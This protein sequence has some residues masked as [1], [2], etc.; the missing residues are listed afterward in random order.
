MVLY[1]IENIML[2]EKHMKNRILLLALVCLLISSLLIACNSKEAYRII[3]VNSF[4]G[5]TSMNRGE[6]AV[7]L[8]EGIQLV[9]NDKVTT[10]NDGLIEL[11][12][13]SDKSLVASENT[14]F[15]IEALGNE[16]Q[17][18][19]TIN[20]EYGTALIDIQNQ[21]TEGSE[22][23]VVTPNATLSVRG[24]TF[25]V[26][27][28]VTTNETI[29]SVTDG[30]V[31]ATTN[32]QSREVN[33]GETVVIRDVN[34]EAGGDMGSGED[35]DNEDDENI[36]HDPSADDFA[37]SE[38]ISFYATDLETEE[39]TSIGV[40]AIEGFTAS[41]DAFGVTQYS[42]NDIVIKIFCLDNDF[43]VSEMEG[44]REPLA[45][46][47]YETNST[48]NEVLADEVLVNDDGDEVQF[49]ETK[50]LWYDGSEVMSGEE[51]TYRYYKEM[52]DGSYLYLFIYGIQPSEQPEIYLDLTKD[53]YFVFE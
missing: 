15:S 45:E 28:D 13:D 17:G 48:E 1:E 44:F 43:Y 46:N 35:G 37:H 2:G 53:C 41:E 38:E 33:A 32:V 3:K 20:L 50:T 11:Q 8:F 25:E 9:S 36:V 21:L 31:E 30:V 22:F 7:D 4:E 52:E 39:V 6:E 16:T 51:T 23:E 29:V 40:K 26:T 47:W 24:T 27:Y 5:E 49:L 34:I 19:V 10:G 18:K 12:V 14:C 42:Y